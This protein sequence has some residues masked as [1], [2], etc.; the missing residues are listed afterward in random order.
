MEL[1]NN[2]LRLSM[3]EG[4]EF[5]VKFSLQEVQFDQF[6]DEPLDQMEPNIMDSEKHYSWY[7]PAHS[8]PPTWRVLVSFIH[9]LSSGPSPLC[10]YSLWKLVRFQSL[11]QE[12]TRRLVL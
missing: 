10:S 9:G 8:N 5:Q 11:L 4:V 2:L 1:C 7:S 12:T 6:G 3:I